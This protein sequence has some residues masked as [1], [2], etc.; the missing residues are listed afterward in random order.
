MTKNEIRKTALMRRD[1][2]GPLQ[3]KEKS[4]IIQGRVRE[5]TEYKDAENLLVYASMRSE[6]ATDDLIVDAL[7]EGKKVFCPKVIDV[8]QGEMRFYR[9]RGLEDLLPGVMGI[10]EPLAGEEYKSGSGRTLVIVPGTA[11][12]VSRNRIGYNGGFYDRFLSGHP[13]ADTAA[14]AFECQI[15]SAVPAM[16]HDIK[17]GKIVTEDRIY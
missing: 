11:F 17:P 5:L 8:R 7:A 3:I 12:D 2:L 1:E 15:F 10:R 9:I 13:D 6:A 14:L 4:R 16:E